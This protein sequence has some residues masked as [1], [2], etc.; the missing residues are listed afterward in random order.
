MGEVLQ[1][2]C[3][4]T[5]YFTMARIHNTETVKRILDDAG[6]QTSQD[7]VPQELASKVVPVLIANP[8]RTSNILKQKFTTGTMYTTPTDKDFFLTSAIIS[9]VSVNESSSGADTLVV[10][11]FGQANVTLLANYN[12]SGAGSENTNTNSQT[13]NPPLKLARGS[14]IAYTLDA[15]AG[16]ATITGY[17]V[18]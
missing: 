16:S 10:T 17:T 13:Y 4:P 14:A 8:L 6:I 12:G 11:P 18:D 5:L 2:R 7:N 3:T 1:G 9:S 15:S